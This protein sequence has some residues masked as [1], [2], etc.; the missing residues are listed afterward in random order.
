MARRI[1]IS[2]ILNLIKAIGGN[3]SKFMG[4]K[5]NINFL[6]K[7]PKQAL[8]QG[9]IDIDGLMQSGFPL[10]R[11][12]SEA[13]TAGGYATANKLNDMQLQRLKDNLITLKQAYKP[14]PVANITDMATGT[15]NLDQ[16]GIMALREGQRRLPAEAHQFMGRPLKDADFVKIDQLVA[17]GKLPGK[18]EPIRPGT[19]EFVD[20]TAEKVSYASRFNPGNEIHVNKA[21]A[22]LE[23]PQIKGVYTEA[24]VKN[25]WDFEGLY[26][27]HFD[28]GHVDVARLLEQE[29]H[30]IPEMRSAA[31]DALLQLLKKEKGL[32]GAEGGLRD[33]VTEVDFKFISEGGGGRTG[34]P[35]NLMVKY[36]GKK[37]T[38]NLPK[39]ATKENIDSFTDFIM[40]AKDSR[41]RGINDPFFDREAID[42][43]QFVRSVDEYVPP[44]E[45]G[46]R[47]DKESGGLAEILQVPRTGFKYGS[48][49]I[50]KGALA[51]LNKNKKNAEYMFKASDNVS[52]GYAHGDIKY[53]AELLADQLAEDAGVVYHDL[54]DL[55]RS[56]F[57]GTAYD[58]LAKEM[59]M[60]LQM[61]KLGQ[62]LEN[63]QML[64]EWTPPEGRKPNA[65][66]GLAQ[67]LE[68]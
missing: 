34:D 35:I 15:R 28:K 31:R 37:A 67:I 53:N 24:E 26:Q 13:E 11:V 66:G 2:E 14:E 30:N 50:A 47:V 20:P 62:V 63:K 27:S 10:N 41:G 12:I 18:G 44:F 61:K 60:M 1:I 32:P 38:E 48:R 65:S 3:P 64:R 40:A 5:S 25:A 23:D 57:Y 55:A 19:Y 59:G 21:K 29:G 54:D 22:L 68:V 43:S 49:T 9:Q 4:T 17:E 46:G 42:F 6:G 51:F 56:E 45:S 7:G 8:F 16:E 58:Y 36:F 52:P 33:F 39:N